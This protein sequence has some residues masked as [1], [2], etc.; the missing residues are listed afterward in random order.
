MVLPISSMYCKKYRL[1]LM[2]DLMLFSPIFRWSIILYR[3]IKKSQFLYC[4]FDVT[5]LIKV[6]MLFSKYSSVVL[7]CYIG[8]SECSVC[9]I[10]QWWQLPCLARMQL[11]SLWS[12]ASN[13]I[14]SS[15]F[16]WNSDHWYNS[17]P[18]ACSFLCYPWNLGAVIPFWE[19]ATV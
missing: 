19:A 10:I 17:F 4:W 6:K 16:A 1:G 14:G 2:R 15:L 5:K 18:Q 3:V 8:K 11:W 9:F 7:L 12:A 13:H